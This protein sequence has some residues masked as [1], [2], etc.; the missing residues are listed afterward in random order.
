MPASIGCIIEKKNQAT[1]GQ[2]ATTLTITKQNNLPTYLHTTILPQGHWNT[3]WRKSILAA[4]TEYRRVVYQTFDTKNNFRQFLTK[5][6]N[7]LVLFSTYW[8]LQDE[9]FSMLNHH[10]RL[11]DEV[12]NLWEEHQEMKE[13][14]A[15]TESNNNKL[16]TEKIWADKVM[17]YVESQLVMLRSAPNA[18]T[19]AQ[20]SSPAANPGPPS[21]HTPATSTSTKATN[22][23]PR[24]MKLL[25]PLIFNGSKKD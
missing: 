24:T 18:S 8:W 4:V 23:R 12:K 9:Y 2:Q 5:E 16:R 22:G 13:K 3:N 15:R 6:N 1:W 19:T 14:L 7:I 10:N 25:D 17:A 20:P 11:A 21:P